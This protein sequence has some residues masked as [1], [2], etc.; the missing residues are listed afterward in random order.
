MRGHEAGRAVR[1]WCVAACSV[2]MDFRPTVVALVGVIQK[3]GAKPESSCK[4]TCGCLFASGILQRRSSF[5]AN[6]PNAH[7]SG[8]PS[9]GRRVTDITVTSA[10]GGVREVRR[11]G[12]R[13]MHCCD[14]GGSCP[15]WCECVCVCVCVC[16]RARARACKI[17]PMR[18][19]Q[20]KRAP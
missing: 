7:S 16:V 3:N 1:R 20:V 4:T 8:I 12:S 17:S 2:S 13:L 5:A 15:V 11:D 10:P 19:S 6:F 18:A 14:E 9:C